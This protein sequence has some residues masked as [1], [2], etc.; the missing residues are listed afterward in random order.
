MENKLHEQ[1]PSAFPALTFRYTYPYKFDQ[2]AAAFLKKY[3]YEPRI[4]L[5]T[6]S[7]VH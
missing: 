5:T 2:I 4:H 6:I 7:G 1:V 3:N